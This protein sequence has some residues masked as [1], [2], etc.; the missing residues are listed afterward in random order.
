MPGSCS[1]GLP[2]VKADIA[3]WSCLPF[4]TKRALTTSSPQSSESQRVRHFSCY[5][6]D[7]TS[8][9]VETDEGH[10]GASC[11]L[12]GQCLRHDVGNEIQNLP[13]KDTGRR[14]AACGVN[15][16]KK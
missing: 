7:A 1:I 8:K 13:K 11:Q 14:V 2:A 4:D 16:R 9:A 6:C 12:S 15:L 3:A 5:S 10:L